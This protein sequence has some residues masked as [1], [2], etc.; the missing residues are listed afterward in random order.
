MDKKI[1]FLKAAGASVTPNYQPCLKH[2]A[3][4]TQENGIEEQG[5]LEAIA[6]AK[7]VKKGAMGKMDRFA[8]AIMGKAKATVEQSEKGCWWS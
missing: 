3:K 7:I 5:I 1:K 2:L 6:V 8:S 4:N